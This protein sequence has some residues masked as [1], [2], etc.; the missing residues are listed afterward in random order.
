MILVVIGNT[1]VQ[2]ANPLLYNRLIFSY[3]RDLRERIIH[4]L[5]RLPIAFVDRGA[6]GKGEDGWSGNHRHRTVGGW[7]DH[8]FNQ[9]F[10]GVLMMVLV[11]IL[12]MLQIHLLMTSWSCCWRRCPWW[13][14]A[15]LPNAPII[16]SRSNRDERNSDSVDWRSAASRPLSSPSM[17]RQSLSKDC[18]R[19]MPTT[20]AILSQLSFIPQRLILLLALSMRSFMLF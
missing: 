7:L 20:Q 11:S 14:H 6:I 10:I 19:Q 4:K 1:L 12:A 16:S 8:D 18:T 17:L 9:F 5:H 13:F 3:T 15:L 2:W